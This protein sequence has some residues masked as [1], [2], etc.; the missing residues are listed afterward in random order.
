MESENTNEIH[1]LTDELKE[2]SLNLDAGLKKRS[3]KKQ[4]CYRTI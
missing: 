4:G 3:N 2:A 1:Q